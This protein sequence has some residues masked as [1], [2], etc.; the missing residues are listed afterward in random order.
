MKRLIMV[1]WMITATLLGAINLDESIELALGN[2][3][4]LKSQEESLKAAKTDVIS[5]YLSLGPSAT[6]GMNY[7]ENDASLDKEDYSNTLSLQVS[8]PI[9]NGGKILLGSMINRDLYEIEEQSLIAKKLEVIAETEN[10]YF[11]VLEADEFMNISQQNFESAE[12]NFQKGEVRF[13]A[14]TISQVELLQLKSDRASKDVSYIQSQNRLKIVKQDLQNYLQLEILPAVQEVDFTQYEQMIDSLKLVKDM[15]SFIPELFQIASQQNPTLQITDISKSTSKKSLWMAAGNFMPSV[16]FSYGKSWG[17]SDALMGMKDYES[18]ENIGINISVPI[19]PIADNGLNLAKANYNLRKATYTAEN[20]ND[21][22]QLA[23][24]NALYTLVS[25]ARLIDS[26]K[27]AYQYAD[28]SY[29]QMEE[30]YNN[31]LITTNDLLAS[32]V[33]MS[34][35]QSA[36]ASAKYDFLRSQTTILQQLGTDDKKM[37]K[38]IFIRGDKK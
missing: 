30:R 24:R 9:F 16:N 27:L 15:N 23:L 26:A 2:N 17:D 29:Q 10:K 32:R 12:V 31:G 7:R 21:G 1:A 36:Y 22:I 4:E 20:T 25:N 5:A 14:G 35:A 37:I 11:L 6:L 13:E 34:S 38:K 19:F 33:M 3:L 18:S 28:E 8:Q